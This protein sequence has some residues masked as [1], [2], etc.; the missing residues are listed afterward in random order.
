MFEQF[1]P[2]RNE[3]LGTCFYQL[4]PVIDVIVYCL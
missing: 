3:P 2:S 1:N 4:P